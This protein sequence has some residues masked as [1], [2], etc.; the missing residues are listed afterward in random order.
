M[1][2]KEGPCSVCGVSSTLRCVWSTH[3]SIC[4]PEHQQPFRF[5]RT[6]TAEADKAKAELASP[7][8]GPAGKS[9]LGAVL[10]KRL[11]CTEDEVPARI[12]ALAAG[13]ALSLSPSNIAAATCTIRN[14]C[15]AMK[16]FEL[17]DDGEPADEAT[18]PTVLLSVFGTTLE[19]FLGGDADDFAALYPA[20]EAWYG[21]L[22]TLA[23]SALAL[24]R[25]AV[26][27]RQK[28]RHAENKRLDGL[29]VQ[30]LRRVA[31]RAGEVVDEKKA[32]AVKQALA[33]TTGEQ[34]EGDNDNDDNYL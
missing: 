34:L 15:S 22:L 23:H 20:G 3:K 14:N 33:M 30:A 29:Y 4:G 16:R 5:P 25:L 31:D 28:G 13:T 2:S 21:E 7:Y 17:R 19:M 6:T 27:A 32:A 10:A 26:T 12:D 9:T 1:S 18:D 8:T 11:G 24:L